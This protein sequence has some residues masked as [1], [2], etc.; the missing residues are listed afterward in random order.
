MHLTNGCAYTNAHT[1]TQNHIFT[2]FL[3]FCDV[4]IT[5]SIHKRGEIFNLRVLANLGYQEEQLKRTAI[6]CVLPLILSKI[7][8]SLVTSDLFILVL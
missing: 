2:I 7:Q 3:A 4:I 1:H 8:F 5:K 6:T